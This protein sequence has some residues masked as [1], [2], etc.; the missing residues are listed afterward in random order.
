MSIEYMVHTVRLISIFRLMIILT[1]GDLMN[2]HGAY[3]LHRCTY[4]ALIWCVRCTMYVYLCNHG[5]NILCT[6]AERRFIKRQK[7]RIH[8]L[9]SKCKV[10]ACRKWICIQHASNCALRFVDFFLLLF[11]AIHRVRPNQNK[12]QYY[13][14]Q[15]CSFKNIFIAKHIFLLIER[16]ACR[17]AHHNLKRIA[18]K[19]WFCYFF[20]FH[21]AY[22][23]APV[24]WT[25]TERTQFQ[26][27]ARFAF[28]FCVG[29]R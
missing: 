2:F 19:C 5:S 4:I 10:A 13:I 29:T 1:F 6:E 9:H 25:Q 28:S 15:P 17:I 11:F 3:T 12:Y 7:N 21:F 22:H 16:A 24:R 27:F 8:W 18:I 23:I 14:I 20:I 26:A